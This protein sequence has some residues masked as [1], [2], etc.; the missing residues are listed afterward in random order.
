MAWS[1]AACFRSPDAGFLTAVFG[2]GALALSLVAAA[3]LQ[4]ARTDAQG[5]ARAAARLR[6]AYAADGVATAAAW[7][8][9]HAADDGVRTWREA[10]SQG[11]FSITVEPEGRKLALDEAS[12]PQG[13]L[14]LTRWLG[15][16]GDDV[17]QRLGDLARHKGGVPSRA[18]LITLSPSPLWRRC[19]LS[20]LSAHSRLSGNVLGAGQGTQVAGAAMERTG[21]VWRIAVARGERPMLDRLVRFTGDPKAPAAVVEETVAAS[22]QG[23]AQLFGQGKD[24]Q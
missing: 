24:G 20:F 21:Q 4:L 22:P 18:E 15:P 16:A 17:A 8:I 23:C 12:G 7:T 14:A 1:R 13:R 10:T 5:A 19:G 9:L 2:V 6:E 11:D 3:G